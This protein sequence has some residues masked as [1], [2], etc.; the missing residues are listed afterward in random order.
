MGPSFFTGIP[1]TAA[2]NIA[3]GRFITTTAT[4][5]AAN[6]LLVQQATSDT[7]LQVHVGVSERWQRYAPNSPGDD[8]YIAILNEEVSYRGPLQIAELKLG[9]T[10]YFNTPLTTDGSGQGIAATFPTAGSVGW[11]PRAIALR[12]GVSGDYIPVYVLPPSINPIS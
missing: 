10:V 8:G 12:N 7:L 5:N 3:P 6:T 1:A 9:G 11:A 4:S 2:G